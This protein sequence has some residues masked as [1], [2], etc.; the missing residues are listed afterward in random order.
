[1]N[2]ECDIKK[3]GFYLGIL[4][5]IYGVIAMICNWSVRREPIES[6]IGFV[7]GLV[8]IV[9]GL[10]WMLVSYVWMK[11]EELNRRMRLIELE[12]EAEEDDGH[13]SGQ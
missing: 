5:C 3:L 13:N 11:L 8:I 7:F 1:M 6:S 10:I 4:M 9:I 12:K 2:N